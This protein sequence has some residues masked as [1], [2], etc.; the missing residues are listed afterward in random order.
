ML[1]INKEVRQGTYLV[2]QQLP[3]LQLPQQ[4]EYQS[5]LLQW[6]GQDRQELFQ[7]IVQQLQPLKLSNTLKVMLQLDVDLTEG[8]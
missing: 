7:L 8:L 2:Q 1:W 5:H 3:Q 4:Q 6:Q